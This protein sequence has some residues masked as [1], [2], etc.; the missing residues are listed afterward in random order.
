MRQV[1]E[2]EVRVLVNALRQEVNLPSGILS[3]A[4]LNAAREMLAY[5]NNLLGDQK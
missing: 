2:I 3:E 4:E 5:Y 1:N